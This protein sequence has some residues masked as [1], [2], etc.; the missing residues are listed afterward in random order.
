MVSAAWLIPILATVVA[1]A[2]GDKE[3]LFTSPNEIENVIY[4]NLKLNLGIFRGPVI[5]YAS[6]FTIVVQNNYI[7]HYA[8]HENKLR[9]RQYFV[10]HSVLLH[11]PLPQL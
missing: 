10:A 11:L 1:L 9:S 3:S 5:S 4:I 7:E 8:H 2:T 6:R